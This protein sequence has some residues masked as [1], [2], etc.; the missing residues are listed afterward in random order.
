MG[1]RAA[2]FALIVLMAVG[3]PAQAGGFFDRVGNAL[4]TF[5][6][7][8]GSEEAKRQRLE[9]DALQ[10]YNQC[11]KANLEAGSTVIDCG[12]PPI[13]M[14]G[15]TPKTER[16]T[17]TCTPIFISDPSRGVTCR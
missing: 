5:G 11:M 6:D 15:S 4:A 14:Q 16:P 8:F 2:V 12:A 9:N 3:S 7:A 1:M 13:A 17:I 10:L